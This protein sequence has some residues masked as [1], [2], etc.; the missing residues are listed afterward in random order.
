MKC[1]LVVVGAGP[2]GSMTAKAAAEAGL[3]VVMMEK[4][5]EIGDPVRCA[6]GVSKAALKKLVEPDPSWISAE[7]KG[8]R[9][10]APDGTEIVISEDRAGAEVGY[11][12]ERKVFDRALAQEAAEAGAKVMVKTRALGLLTEKGVPAGVVAQ[13]VGEE[14][15]IEAPLVIGADGVESKVGRWAGIETALKPKDVETCAQFLVQDERIDDD[16]CEFYL[17]NDIAPGGYV[18]SFPKGRALANVGIGILGSKADSGTPIRLLRDFM[19][20]NFPEGKVLEMMVGG[21]PVSGP[22]ERTVADGVILVGDAARQSDP[23]TGGGIINAMKAGKMAGKIAADLVPRGEVDKRSLMVY[24]EM[25]RETIGKHISRNFAVKEFFVDLTDD[26]LNRMIHSLDG[27]DVA[28]LD[29]KGLLK[30][31]VR[32]NPKHLLKLRHLIV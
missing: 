6:E 30:V 7:V 12:L 21:V 32:Q 4:R 22:I 29:L 23:I 27:I 8:A 31:L 17:G 28:E 20:A 3:D 9:I 26:D 10:R 16:Y 25:W 13:F 5:Q 24:E 15:K 1:D 2:A 18:W 19:K 14:L 11:V